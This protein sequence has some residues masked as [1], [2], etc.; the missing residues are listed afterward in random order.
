M[1]RSTARSGQDCALRLQQPE[2]GGNDQHAGEGSDHPEAIGEVLIEAVVCASAILRCRPSACVLVFLPSLPSGS[3]ARPQPWTSG[4][5]IVSPRLNSITRY[6]AVHRLVIV[7]PP[8]AGL[9][10]LRPVR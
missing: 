10:R 5:E 3:W 6:R 1:G 2:Q 7:A 8:S 4:G 9:P